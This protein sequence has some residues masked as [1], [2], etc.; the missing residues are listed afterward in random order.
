CMLMAQNAD[1]ETL[2]P[3]SATWAPM[4]ATWA[5]MSATWAPMSATW[6]PM[7]A[8]WAPMSATWA[9]MSATWVPV[10]VDELSIL[11]EAPQCQPVVP[12]QGWEWVRYRQKSMQTGVGGISDPVPTS[13]FDIEVCDD[14][15]RVALRLRGFSAR[16][17]P[18]EGGQALPYVP[19]WDQI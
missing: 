3:A 1:Q 13:V 6:A 4:S 7:S 9:P 14:E 11:S 17:L 16:R 5:P 19:F 2:A 10:A 12:A 8:T 18:E 15:G